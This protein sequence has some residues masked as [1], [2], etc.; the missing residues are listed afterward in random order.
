ME[1]TDPIQTQPT[2]R[3]CWRIVQWNRV[4]VGLRRSSQTGRWLTSHRDPSS[5]QSVMS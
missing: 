5:G 2:G 1:Q 4:R 3:F